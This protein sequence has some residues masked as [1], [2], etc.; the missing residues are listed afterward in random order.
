MARRLRAPAA[1]VRDNQRPG[2]MNFSQGVNCRRLTA[3]MG[4]GRVKTHTARVKSGLPV[5]RSYVSSRRVRTWVRE[6]SPLAKPHHSALEARTSSPTL[7]TPRPSGLPPNPRDKPGAWCLR[8]CSRLG[9]FGSVSTNI[10]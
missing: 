7:P 5:R 2:R 6:K 8:Q 1:V 9:N 10:R 4:L 3:A